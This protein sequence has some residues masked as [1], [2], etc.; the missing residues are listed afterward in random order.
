MKYSLPVILTVYEVS[1][2]G[3]RTVA[4]DEGKVMVCA[5]LSTLRLL[6]ATFDIPVT[7]ATRNGTGIRIWTARAN[8]HFCCPEKFVLQ[9]IFSVSVFLMQSTGKLN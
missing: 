2:P 9:V 6:N 8:K 5:V 3:T 1:I 4:E 7:L